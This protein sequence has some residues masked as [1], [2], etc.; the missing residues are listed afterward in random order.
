MKN[1]LW[2]VGLL[3]V[4]CTGCSVGNAPE[5]MSEAQLADSV[6]KLKPQD[7]INYIRVM[8][9]PQAEKDRRIAEIEQKFGMKADAKGS[10][11]PSR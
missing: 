11:T 2:I 3:V 7:Q 9:I 4:V 1:H 6:S 8:P 5:P 10:Q